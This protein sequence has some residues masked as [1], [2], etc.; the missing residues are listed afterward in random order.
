MTQT[1]SVVEEQRKEGKVIDI[2][3]DQPV[4]DVAKEIKEKLGL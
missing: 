3:A 4:E 2:N 1:L